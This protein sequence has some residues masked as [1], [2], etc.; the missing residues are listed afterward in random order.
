MTEKGTVNIEITVET[1]GGHSSVPPQH[2][3]IGI[4]ALAIAEVE[5]HP[6]TPTLPQ[7]SPIYGFLQCAAGH[8]AGLPEALRRTV[9]SA[10]GGDHTAL[11]ALP[12]EFI[13][14]GFDGI[15]VGP[16]QGSSLKALMGTTQATDII[17]GGVKVNALYV[18]PRRSSTN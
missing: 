8:A 10:A 17:N 4:L 14:V 3:A 1:L 13:Q 11:G 12:E 5:K 18:A 6:H 9:L 15:Q 2:T 7:Y 16:G